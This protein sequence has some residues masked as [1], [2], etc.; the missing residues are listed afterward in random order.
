MI[1]RL[2]E[3]ARGSGQKTVVL[4]RFAVKR[5]NYYMAMLGCAHTQVCI[6]MGRIR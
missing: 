5:E 1:S 3:D 4:I 2:L 6:Y